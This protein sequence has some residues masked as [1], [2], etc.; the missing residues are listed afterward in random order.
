MLL[1]DNDLDTCKE[2]KYN[3]DCDRFIFC[4]D[5]GLASE[6]NRLFNHTGKRGFIVTQFIKKLA[7]EYREE[8]LHRKGFRRLSDG[9]LVDLERLGEEDDKELFYKEELYSSKKLEQRLIITYSPKYAA[10]QKELR[11]KQ[12][13]RAMDMLKDG[14][15][16]KTRR[17]PNDPARFIDRQAVTLPYLL[18]IAAGLPSGLCF[19]FLIHEAQHLSVGGLNLRALLS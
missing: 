9:K 14:R 16:K 10:Y 5:A 12:V 7:T 19:S 17:N 15:H 8:A 13:K 18:L 3:L 11:E 6:N 2:V 1:I 4:S